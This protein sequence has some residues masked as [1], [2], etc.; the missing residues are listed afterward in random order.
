MWKQKLKEN[1]GS[2]L[3]ELLM[4]V[5]I[6][7]LIGSAMGGGL[8]VVQRCYRQ[9]TERAHAA[10]LLSTTATL[11]TDNLEY[12]ADLS[13]GDDSISFV[14]AN[15]KARARISWTTAEGI[16]LS[17]ESGGSADDGAAVREGG[18]VVTGRK[19]ALVSEAGLTDALY[20]R[21]DSISY[22]TEK[23]GRA[24]ITVKGLAVYRKPAGNSSGTAETAENADTQEATSGER[25]A[26]TDLQIRT[27]NRLQSGKTE[28]DD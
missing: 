8:V 19:T 15:T 14:N 6:I 9:F 7:T 5:L 23:D 26:E 11:L 17:F 21:F 18:S 2:T 28:A 16:I 27:V 25:L 24:L 13:A 12:A 20:T 1:K 22:R 10:T 4:T 3:P